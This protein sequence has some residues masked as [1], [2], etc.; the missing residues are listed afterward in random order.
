MLKFSLQEKLELATLS[1][2]AVRLV[3]VLLPVDV[4]IVGYF[5]LNCVVTCSNCLNIP[6]NEVY[7]LGRF[8]VVKVDNC[9]QVEEDC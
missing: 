1:Y 6:V 2:H 4:G 5:V 7:A 9:V 3:V 8:D